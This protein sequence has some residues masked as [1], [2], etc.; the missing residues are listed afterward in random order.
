MR[1]NL[2]SDDLHDWLVVRFLTLPE[3]TLADAVRDLEELDEDEKQNLNQ[4]MIFPFGAD[5]IRAE[6]TQLIAIYGE[7]TRV[8]EFDSHLP[9][10]Y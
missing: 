7:H 3:A 10:M 6:L 2:C 9:A 5:D 1:S 8:N 4:N